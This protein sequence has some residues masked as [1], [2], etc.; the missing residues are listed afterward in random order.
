MFMM[1]MMRKDFSDIILM[2]LYDNEVPSSGTFELKMGVVLI[3]FNV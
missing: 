3:A 1:G 2:V